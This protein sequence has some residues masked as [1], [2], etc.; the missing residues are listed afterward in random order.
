MVQIGRLSESQHGFDHSSCCDGG[1][2]VVHPQDPGTAENT[3]RGSGDRRGHAVRLRQAR[4]LTDEVLVGHGREHRQTKIGNLTQAA[5]QFQRVKGVLVEVVA[6]V[7][8]D[9]VL[10]DPMINS[11]L[12][13]SGEESLDFGR[14]VAVLRPTMVFPRQCQAVGDHQGR[15]LGR[16]HTQPALGRANPWGR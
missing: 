11:Q 6:R 3:D 12:H 7:D 8:D 13:T 14:D 1:G 5:R 15:T 16:R 2:D 10:R 4:R 9:P